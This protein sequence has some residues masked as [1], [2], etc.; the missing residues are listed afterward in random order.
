MTSDPDEAFRWEGDDARPA[1]PEPRGSAPANDRADA[2]AQTAFTEASA[3]EPVVVADEAVE[4][5]DPAGMSTAMLLTLGVVGGVYL[6][7]SIGWAIGGARLQA[8]ARFVVTDAMYVPWM[9][10]AVLAPALWF[11][12]AWVLT[13]GAA[14]WARLLALLA[15]AVLLVPWPFVLMGAFGS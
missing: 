6:L 14:S 4:A 7:Y 10:L 3:S 8:F 1:R 5:N 15:G 12:A 2:A 9:W 11:I 13:R